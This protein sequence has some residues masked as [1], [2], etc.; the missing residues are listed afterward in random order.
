[1]YLAEMSSS[2]NMFAALWFSSTAAQPALSP[3]GFVLS[4]SSASTKESFQLSR[5]SFDVMINRKIMMTDSKHKDEL[6]TSEPNCCQADHCRIVCRVSFFLVSV[7]YVT[8]C[9]PDE[10]AV[11][12]LRPWQM[13]L[14]N[15]AFPRLQQ[16]DPQWLSLSQN[17]LRQRVFL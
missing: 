10:A 14:M 8:S 5:F 3:G 17:A 1:M 7:G 16:M 11:P 4:G 2:R 6:K 9:L 13:Q 15:G 12:I